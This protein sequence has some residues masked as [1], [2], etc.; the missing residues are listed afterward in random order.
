MSETAATTLASALGVR[1]DCSSKPSKATSTEVVTNSGSTSSMAA[2]ASP[3]AT[4]AVGVAESTCSI[5]SGSAISA[6]HTSSGDTEVSAPSALSAEG[7]SALIGACAASS[8]CPSS[9]PLR[10]AAALPL[11]QAFEVSLQGATSLGRVA[12]TP[13][14]TG[15]RFAANFSAICCSMLARRCLAA[16]MLS[17]PELPVFVLAAAGLLG[18]VCLEPCGLRCT[19]DSAF[20]SPAASFSL[21]SLATDKRATTS[22]ARTFVSLR[23]GDLAAETLPQEDERA[24]ASKERGQAVLSS[25]PPAG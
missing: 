8:T 20:E 11:M 3:S 5:P 12:A 21:A 15:T 18:E 23:S 17:M 6:G 1:E 13:S 19:P 25:H 7:N 10:G 4:A 2:A 24:I 14:S 9:W 16:S 22:A